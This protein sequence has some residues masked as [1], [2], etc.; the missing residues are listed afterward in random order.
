[1]ENKIR[2]N[3]KRI[4]EAMKNRRSQ[5]L[6]NKQ[7]QEIGI[8]KPFILRKILLSKKRLKCNLNQIKL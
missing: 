6:L 7:V 2:N 5:I 4:Q 8:K 1:M 3:K